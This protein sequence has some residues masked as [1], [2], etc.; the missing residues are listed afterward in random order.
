MHDATIRLRPTPPFDL[1]ASLRFLGRFPA[2]EGEQF[3]DDTHLV[4][5]LREGG[6]TVLVRLSSRGTIEEPDVACELVAD[7]PITEPA[8][9]AVSD[10]LRFW[11]GLDDDV[12][13][14]YLR[15]D[16]V[17]ATVV[18][19]LYGYHQV[20]FPSPLEN[21]CWAILAQRAPRRVAQAAKRRLIE[22]FD[23]HV[24][25]DGTGYRAFP[26]LAQLRSLTDARLAELVRNDRKSTYLRGAFESLAQVDEQFL[27]SGPYDDVKSYL[28]SIPGIGP[29][30]ASFVLI[31][32]LGRTD[33]MPFDKEGA[34]AA[35]RV[36]GRE[37]TEGEFADLASRYGPWQGY[38]GH[39][40][41]AV[42]G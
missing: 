21:V 10:R 3:V 28:L 1:S 23:N 41:R 9:A 17:F 6:L 14:L 37:L 22:C 32:G 7:E 34:T 36:Y 15:A 33:E 16:E 20:K 30:S 25:L 18:R 12:A 13:E 40:L 5:A 11:L 8:I 31:R 19:R 4:K 29:W 42:T 39:Y 35:S 26:D 24:E 2:T 27:R 38:W